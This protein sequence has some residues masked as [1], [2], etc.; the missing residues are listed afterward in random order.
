MQE[1]TLHESSKALHTQTHDRMQPCIDACGYCHEICLQT[2]MTHCLAVGGK[3]VEAGHF[4]LMINCAEICQT[5][6]NL[7]LSGSAHH[8]AVCAAC[9]DICDACADSCEQIGDMDG[10]VEACRECA[11]SCR[12]MAGATH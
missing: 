6:A 4:R 10:C 3:H 9:A 8:A 7:M 5:A 2:A 11:E 1:Q 12:E